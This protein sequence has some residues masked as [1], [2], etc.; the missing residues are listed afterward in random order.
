MLIL[1]HF[2]LRASAHIYSAGPETVY[3]GVA[4]GRRLPEENEYMH[5]IKPR[6]FARSH[7]DRYER[8]Q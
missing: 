1:A 6:I 8:R 7:S 5:K 3:A 2:K 4:N